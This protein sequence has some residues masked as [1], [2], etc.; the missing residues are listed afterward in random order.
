[1]PDP[2]PMEPNEIF[3]SQAVSFGWLKVEP[4]TEA[5]SREC[6]SPSTPVVGIPTTPIVTNPMQMGERLIG[7]N[8]VIFANRSRPY[9]RR[10]V[11]GR[12]EQTLVFEPS[13]SLLEAL[14][15][16]YDPGFY[17]GPD[18]V[19]RHGEGLCP[20]G[21]HLLARRLI[22]AAD[23]ATVR[24]DA[25][26]ECAFWLLDQAF[27]HSWAHWDRLPEARAET[28]RAHL[29]LVREACEYLVSR[30][31]DPPSLHELGRHVSM[32]P[33]HFCR[34]FRRYTGMTVHAYQLQNRLR[35]VLVMLEDERLP[36]SWIAQAVGFSDQAH[37]TR[38]FRDAFG[39]TPGVFRKE[40][41]QSS[42]DAAQRFLDAMR[43]N[44][45]G[46]TASD[47]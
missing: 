26:E 15:E 24:S 3:R 14:V 18:Q 41:A 7:P 27:Q 44:V 25:L 8:N 19:F 46:K 33:Q 9:T 43:T 2:C 12:G 30:V 34:V 22:R 45:Q 31:A 10:D 47:K 32:S 13:A 23:A 29:N 39:L 42:H 20:P 5:W 4:G 1:M 21:V 35:T 28:S 17:A 16:R 40:L 6:L 11:S 37:L 36:L 38:S